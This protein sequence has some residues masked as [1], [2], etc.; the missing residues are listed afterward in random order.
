MT[1]AF[2]NAIRMVISS[3]IPLVLLAPKCGEKLATPGRLLL[4][5]ESHH[6]LQPGAEAE[7]AEVVALSAELL[8]SQTVSQH[9]RGR[10]VT[11]T[12]AS[13]LLPP[14]WPRLL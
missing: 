7:V 14:P 11:W 4:H 6:R 13:C 5:L 9:Q 3:L 1:L 10:L 2:M 8:T 12:I